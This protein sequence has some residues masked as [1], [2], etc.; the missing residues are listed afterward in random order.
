MNT[1]SQSSLRKLCLTLCHFFPVTFK[2][3]DFLWDF[4]LVNCDWMWE[5]SLICSRS[6]SV[7]DLSDMLS[8]SSLS[9][10]DFS[11]M[12]S[13]SSLRVEDFFLTCCPSN[14]CFPWHYIFDGLKKSFL[15]P[16][17]LEFKIGL[18]N[19]LNWIV[20]VWVRIFS[21]PPIRLWV[22]KL[23]LAVCSGCLRLICEHCR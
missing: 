11:D 18:D 22:W 15:F 19:L 16:V 17:L 21:F 4:L 10:E 12:L 5:L 14:L 7:E 3:K 2:C 23:S 13:Q 8:Q 9:V 1:L 6:L 20:S